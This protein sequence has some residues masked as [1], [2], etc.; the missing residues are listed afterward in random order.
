MLGSVVIAEV[1]GLLDGSRLDQDALRDGLTHDIRSWESPRLRVDLFL[2][3]GDD[4]WG[5]VDGE[6]DNLRIDAVFGLREEIGSDKCWVGGFVGD[7]LY[8]YVNP[9]PIQTK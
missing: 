6:E 2:N 7:D 4:F 8:A 9:R 1:H 3:F 5:E